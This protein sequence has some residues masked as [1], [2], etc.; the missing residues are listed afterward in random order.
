MQGHEILLL[1]LMVL[2]FI[3]L[4]ALAVGFFIYSKSIRE[5]EWDGGDPGP[6]LRKNKDDR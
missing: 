4:V 3:Y 2:I 6:Y 5:D 1:I